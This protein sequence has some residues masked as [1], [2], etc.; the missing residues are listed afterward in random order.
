M[1]DYMRSYKRFPAAMLRFKLRIKQRS[2]FP[3]VKRNL[4]LQYM[5][6]KDNKNG[7]RLKLLKTRIWILNI[8]L[9]IYLQIMK[10][11][12]LLISIIMWKLTQA[13]IGYDC[14]SKV[15]NMTT[16]SLLDIDDC[17]LETDRVDMSL[18]DLFLLQLNEYEHTKT[19]QCKIEINRA[20]YY[21]GRSSHILVSRQSLHGT[22]PPN[23]A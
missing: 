14:G 22:Y 21:C 3:T 8:N 18:V 12:T 11:L 5:T 17:D 10:L 23:L 1:T 4:R 2:F 19:T 13:M 9:F 6:R 20:I 16:I 15:L 7:K